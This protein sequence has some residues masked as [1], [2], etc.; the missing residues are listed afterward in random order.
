ME[1]MLGGHTTFI[2]SIDNSKG[3][4][5]SHSLFV[6]SEIWD[7]T[8]VGSMWYNIIRK[9]EIYMVYTITLTSG[10]EFSSFQKKKLNKSSSK[11]GLK[12]ITECTSTSVISKRLKS[13]SIKMGWIIIT[14]VLIILGEHMKRDIQKQNDK[15]TEEF[16]K[17]DKIRQLTDVIRM[18]QNEK[19]SNTIQKTN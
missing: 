8:K 6:F 5:V 9:G 16:I 4:A 1:T 19:D 12:W 17:L 15:M 3:V 10:K 14:I 13:I 7:L 2:T 18:V 11:D